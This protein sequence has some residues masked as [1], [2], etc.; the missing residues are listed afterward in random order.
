VSLN[1][2][3]GHLRAVFLDNR[4]L[5]SLRM[6]RQEVLAVLGAPGEADKMVRLV[7]AE[8]NLVALARWDEEGPGKRWRLFR[9]FAA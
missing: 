5:S 6:G 4:M 2:A 8:N 1:A 9:M 3:L 7:D